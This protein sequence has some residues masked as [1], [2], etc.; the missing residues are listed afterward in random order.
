MRVKKVD[1]YM[2]ILIMMDG[3]VIPF[4]DIIHIDGEIFETI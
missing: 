4:D 1:L 3:N 2:R